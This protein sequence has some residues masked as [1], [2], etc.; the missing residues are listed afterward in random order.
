MR[1]KDKAVLFLETALEQRLD[2]LR[3]EHVGEPHTTHMWTLGRRWHH[4]LLS[5]AAMHPHLQHPHF[6][7]VATIAH[8][9]KFISI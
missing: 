4:W 6:S 9:I 3:A 5:Y 2:D 7:S 1:D 8:K